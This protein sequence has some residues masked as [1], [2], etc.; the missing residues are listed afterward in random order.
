VA[1]SAEVG[2]TN[3]STGNC[4]P[5]TMIWLVILV[6]KK[7]K[8]QNWLSVYFWSWH[9]EKVKQLIVDKLI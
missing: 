9:V 2:P 7:V 5:C 6:Y 8:Q 1:T 4:V 3:I